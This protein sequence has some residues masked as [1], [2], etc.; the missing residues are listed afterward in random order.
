MRRDTSPYLLTLASNRGPQHGVVPS[1][2]SS[3]SLKSETHY[4]LSTQSTSPIL[5]L[6]SQLLISLLPHTHIACILT[7]F[8]TKYCQQHRRYFRNASL[9]PELYSHPTQSHC[10]RS[11]PIPH[12]VREYN[13]HRAQASAFE[14]LK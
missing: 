9:N 5:A 1:L 7:A 12:N 13:L 14:P 2:H 6:P 10:L 3:F 11:R 4:S 8:S